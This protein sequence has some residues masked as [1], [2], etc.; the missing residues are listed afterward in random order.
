MTVK[1]PPSHRPRD[2]AASSALAKDRPSGSWLLANNP[3]LAFSSFSSNSSADRP[4]LSARRPTPLTSSNSDTATTAP[5]MKSPSTGQ[6]TRHKSTT[7]QKHPEPQ[8]QEKPRCSISF[9]SEFPTLTG[10]SSPQTPNT[11]D[12]SPS[13]SS[14]TQHHVWGNTQRIQ[15]K[16]KS[17]AKASWNGNG[18][19]DEDVDNMME[20]ERL[21]A[22]V[23]RKHSH[24]QGTAT[25]TS[26]SGGVHRRRVPSSTA[27]A[28]SKAI[29]RK[30]YRHSPPQKF[31][32]IITAT[33]QQDSSSLS[34]SL[35]SSTSSILSP[36]PPLSPITTNVS[37]TTTKEPVPSSIH[38][39]DVVTKQDQLRFYLFLK[40]WTGHSVGDHGADSS[41][42]QQHH[43]CHTIISR[44]LPIG[45]QRQDADTTHIF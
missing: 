43:Q 4:I 22:L 30:R 39:N 17:P 23:P 24:H 45:A 28:T 31:A 10:I 42:R 33:P 38:Q 7:A 3:T 41:E 1:S 19:D 21:K 15:H 35:S 5:M 32:T 20:I 37:G 27:T 2:P 34:S 40:R 9:D 14:A 6:R 12:P 16:V 25:V 11:A 8:P 18:C 36:S 44:P 13:S 26:S 29:T